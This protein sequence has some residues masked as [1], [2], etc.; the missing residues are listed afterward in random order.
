VGSEAYNNAMTQFD[1]SKN[2]AYGSARDTATAGGSHGSDEPVW[3]GPARPEP[4]HC[5]A[6]AC[7]AESAETDQPDLRW[8]IGMSPLAQILA[9]ANRPA[10]APG[11]VNVATTPVASIYANHDQQQMDAYKQKV[12]Q[13]NAMWGGLASLAGCRHQRLRAWS[14]Q[15]IHVCARFWIDPIDCNRAWRW[16]RRPS[17]HDV[18]RS[19]SMA[20][21]PL[22]QAIY[23]GL[24]PSVYQPLQQLETG[25]ALTQAGMDASPTSKWGALGRVAQAL[26]GSYL[27]NTS[28]SKLA[29]TIAGGKKQAMEDLMSALQ[30]RAAVPSALPQ[31][32]APRPMAQ[33]PT[34]Q[35]MPAV[36]ATPPEGSPAAVV[37]DRFPPNGR[38]RPRRKK[39]LRLRPPRRRED[40]T[41][42]RRSPR[43]R[44]AAS[45]IFSAQ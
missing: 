33:A 7:A 29:D 23:K 9:T 42:V 30:P 37:A 24:D 5:A 15:P 32:A 13:E 2:Q 8:S 40:P 17:V 39:P 12:S 10:P 36:Q 19:T 38:R 6:A 1:S 35:P 28:R 31:S 45:T 41:T 34:G 18:L 43:S 44:A 27:T 21:T 16:Y 3:P 20:I 26:S 25:D 22:S 11:Q 14:R 4:K